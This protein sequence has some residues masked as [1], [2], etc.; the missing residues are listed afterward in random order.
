[1]DLI[2]KL[3][4][5]DLIKAYGEVIKEFK[6]RGIIRSKNLLGDLGEYLAINQYCSTIGLPNLQPAPIG[7]KNIDAIS[8]KGERYSIKSTTGKVTGV[9]TDLMSRILKNRNYKNLNIL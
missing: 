4:D 1:M 3:S 5:D 8:V 6:K 7:T 9:F 2:S